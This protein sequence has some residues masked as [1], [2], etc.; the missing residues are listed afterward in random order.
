MG[1]SERGDISTDMNFDELGT[2]VQAIFPSCSSSIKTFN[3]YLLYFMKEKAKS[4]SS[5]CLTLRP[6]FTQRVNNE[7]HPERKLL[8]D[9]KN[10]TKEHCSLDKFRNLELGSIR[11]IGK[12]KKY[13]VSSK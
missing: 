7:D 13:F 6:E 3:K 11:F 1:F 2:E 4:K 10:C 12:F 8:S 5:L 9:E